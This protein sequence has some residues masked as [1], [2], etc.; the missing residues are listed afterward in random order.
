MVLDPTTVEPTEPSTVDS[1]GFLGLDACT[2]AAAP[3]VITTSLVDGT[4][5]EASVGLSLRQAATIASAARD[6]RDVY[7]TGGV[8]TDTGLRPSQAACAL[9]RW[10]GRSRWRL[11]ALR[12]GL[13][14]GVPFS[15]G[16]GHEQ[17]SGPHIPS[18]QPL[19]MYRGALRAAT[20][21]AIERPRHHSAGAR[22]AHAES[23]YFAHRRSVHKRMSAAALH[24]CCEQLQPCRRYWCV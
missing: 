4:V 3:S 2:G 18:A 1:D 15:V 23:H 20:G 19:C 16:R 11:R 7:L 13:T 6:R 8:S 5:L 17:C 21:L 24:R 12:T 10:P 22:S 9:L 14:A